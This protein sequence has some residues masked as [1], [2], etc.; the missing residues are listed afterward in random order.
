MSLSAP[1]FN[2]PLEGADQP[3]VDMSKAPLPTKQTLAARKNLLVQFG[4]FLSINT[5]IMR[6][7]L[8]G[9]H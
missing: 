5:N 6:M 4:R 9:H 3:V 7:V 2:T 8:K 1:Q